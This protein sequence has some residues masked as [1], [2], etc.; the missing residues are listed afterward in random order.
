MSV[1][2]LAQKYAAFGWN[3]IEI[4]GHDIAQILDAFARTRQITDCPT[5]ILA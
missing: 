4:N 1:E 5:V 2:L 3:V